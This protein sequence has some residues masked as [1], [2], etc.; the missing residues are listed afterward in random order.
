[1]SF[2]EENPDYIWRNVRDPEDFVDDSFQAIPFGVN[3]TLIVGRPKDPSLLQGLLNPEKVMVQAV[4][5]DKPDWTLEMSLEWL[6]ENQKDFSSEAWRDRKEYK[7]K[8][9]LKSIDAVEIFSAGTWNG[10]TYSVKD[11]D[12][13]VK[14]FEET[15]QTVRPFLKLGHSDDQKLLQAEG[16]PAAGWIGRVYR[17]GEKLLA[18]FVDMPKTIYELI[19]KKAYRKVSSEIYVGV[20][21]KDKAYKYMLGAVALLGSELPGVMNLKDILSRYG[22]KDFEDIKSYTDNQSDLVVKAYSIDTNQDNKGEEDP[23]SKTEREIQLEQQ[24]SDAQA[25]VKK[26]QTEATSTDELLK[27]E[28][29]KR[30]AAEKK[31]FEYEQT[32]K[33]AEIEKQAAELVGEKLITAGQKPYAIALL[34]NE[35]DPE[36]KKY[37]FKAGDQEKSLDRFELLKEFTQLFSKKSE[38]N[39]EENSLDGDKGE[40]RG[41]SVDDIE[42]FATEHKLSFA[43]AYKEMLAGKLKPETEETED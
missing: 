23:M 6:Q 13:M 41:P 3:M 11:L 32:A 21:I 34:K 18:D 38:V 9:E 12:E 4:K 40:N 29:E 36:T 27:A 5:F 37:S 8:E 35:T 39:F 31:A 30:E 25:E 24:L 19:E 43:A 17:K 10:D 22:L 7:Q 15:S 1:M 33:N 20:K 16:L 42:K 26:F 28:T 2:L 14:A